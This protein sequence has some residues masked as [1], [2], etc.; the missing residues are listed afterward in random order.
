MWLG[1]VVVA[2]TVA[3]CVGLYLKSG[4]RATNADDCRVAREMIDYNKSQSA[5]FADAFD[6]EEGREASVDD[7]RRWADQM[8]AY[9]TQINAPEV[10]TPAA[11]LAVGADEL[12]ALL[13]Q[14][15]AD[16]SVPA[17]PSAP[18]RWAQ[19]YGELATQFH[20]DLVALSD[21]CSKR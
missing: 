16:T 5:F 21:A 1:V 7:Y 15:R 18:P 8:R 14:A 2:V 17:D 9:S 12:V 4:G 11:R 20:D 19:R 6:W 13:V 10:S 3:G